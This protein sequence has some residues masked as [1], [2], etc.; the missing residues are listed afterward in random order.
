M[1]RRVLFR[2]FT[3]ATL[4]ETV[5]K[6]TALEKTDF[7]GASLFRAMLAGMDFSRCTLDKIILSAS[8]QELKGAKINTQQAAIVAK[9]LGIEVIP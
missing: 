3:E 1:F 8:C 6:K 9:I 2:S 5:F 4:Q 7:T